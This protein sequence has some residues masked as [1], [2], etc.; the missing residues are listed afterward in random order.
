MNAGFLHTV[1]VGPVLIQKPIQYEPISA[2]PVGNLTYEFYF[3]YT[4]FS[5][6][7]GNEIGFFLSDPTIESAAGSGF[8]GRAMSLQFSAASNVAFALTGNGAATPMGFDKKNKTFINLYFDDS[9]FVPG[10]SPDLNGNYD[11]CKLTP[12]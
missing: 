8:Y 10:Q 1:D 7:Q 12:P 2:P 6:S 3:N 9:T 4:G 5:Q 11:F